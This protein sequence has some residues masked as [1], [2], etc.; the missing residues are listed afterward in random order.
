MGHDG[1]NHVVNETRLKEIYGATMARSRDE[2]PSPESLLALARREGSEESR[3][4]TLDH[5]MSCASCRAELD[6]LRSIERAGAETGAGT[7]A[8]RRSGRRN[9]F[10]PAALAATVL[11]AVGIG[12]TVLVPGGG[13]PVRSGHASAL[14]VVAPA[15]EAAV[16]EP[17]TFAWRPVDGAVRYRVELMNEGGDV[18]I[19]AETRDT[20]VTLDGVRRLAEGDYRWWVLAM[21]PRPGPRSELRLLR[22]TAR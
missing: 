18:A 9:W 2:H 7:G 10:V 1:R 5:A 8:A 16:G 13:E 12:R 14:A 11:L 20:A 22:L 6:L 3:L 17:L 15:G 19:E 21:T 4:A